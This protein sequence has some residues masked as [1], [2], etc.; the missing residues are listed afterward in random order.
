MVVEVDLLLADDPS[1]N[2]PDDVFEP[3]E[4]R[5]SKTKKAKV[6]KS[7]DAPSKKRTVDEAKFDVR[8]C[9]R[10]RLGIVDA[11]SKSTGNDIDNRSI[12]NMCG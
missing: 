4:T 8:T 3:G 11:P 6:A 1:Y 12:A 2:L 10:A 7:G 5:P 9:K